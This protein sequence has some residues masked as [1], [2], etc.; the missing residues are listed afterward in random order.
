MNE[1]SANELE[2]L[3]CSIEKQYKYCNQCQK[4]EID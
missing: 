1:H 4:L 2:K 3:H